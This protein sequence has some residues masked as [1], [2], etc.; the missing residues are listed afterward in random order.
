MD[1]EEEEKDEEEEE[2][3]EKE[4]E[5]EEEEEATWFPLVTVQLG[6]PTLA[7]LQFTLKS[8]TLVFLP[9]PN[10]ARSPS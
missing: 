1:E 3:E 5:E 4:E 6:F 10:R 8:K 2:E 7:H 9:E